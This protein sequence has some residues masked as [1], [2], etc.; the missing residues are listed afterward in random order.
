ML[1]T[2]IQDFE[3][4]CQVPHLD[5]WGYTMNLQRP[6][7]EA[8]STMLSSNSSDPNLVANNMCLK[9]LT[10]IRYPSTKQVRSFQLKAAFVLNAEESLAIEATQINRHKKA[11]TEALYNAQ[12]N[13][14]V[15]TQRYFSQQNG[16]KIN[17]SA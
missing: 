8:F 4:K 11:L 7:I 9:N 12:E 1:H 17:M 3:T 16:R 14:T 15:T 13:L 5:L 6:K 2:K 10:H